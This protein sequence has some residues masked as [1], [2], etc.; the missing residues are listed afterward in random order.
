MRF[1][2]GHMKASRDDGMNTR[3]T[4]C[5]RVCIA[6]DQRKKTKVPF[7][8]VIKLFSSIHLDAELLVFSA[9]SWFLLLK[10]ETQREEKKPELIYMCFDLTAILGLRASIVLEIRL[11]VVFWNLRAENAVDSI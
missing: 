1:G 11:V 4:Q 8:F 6:A 3:T 9:F 10:R 5:T 2:L 7:T